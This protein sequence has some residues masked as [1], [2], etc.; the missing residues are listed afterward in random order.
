[1]ALID[2]QLLFKDCHAIMHTAT[3]PSGEASRI[4]MS[5]Y[6]VCSLPAASLVAVTPDGFPLLADIDKPPWEAVRYIGR[7]PPVKMAILVAELVG[8]K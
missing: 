6:G 2:H 5:H 1:V 3:T 8:S 7:L 4:T